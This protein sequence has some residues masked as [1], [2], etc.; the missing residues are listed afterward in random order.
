MDGRKISDQN[1]QTIEHADSGY[2]MSE[3]CYFRQYRVNN[4]KL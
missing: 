1:L 3:I 2:V 4:V